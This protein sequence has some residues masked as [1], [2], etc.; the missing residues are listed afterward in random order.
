MASEGSGQVK[1]EGRDRDQNAIGTRRAEGLGSESRYDFTMP[2][3]KCEL[4]CHNWELRPLLESVQNGGC[5]GKDVGRSRMTRPE[6]GEVTLMRWRKLEDARN[7]KIQKNVGWEGMNEGKP[8]NSN[9][10]KDEH[11][12]QVG[13]VGDP[14]ISRATDYLFI[15]EETQDGRRQKEGGVQNESWT[16]RSASTSEE[17]ARNGGGGEHSPHRLL[18]KE[19]G[20][21]RGGW[22]LLQRLPKKSREDEG[23]DAKGWRMGS[24]THNPDTE[25]T[26]KNAP[27]EPQNNPQDECRAKLPDNSKW[28]RASSQQASAF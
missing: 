6:W 26:P 27:E 15:E 4:S 10:P 5:G 25:M 28:P 23:D 22:C 12:R 11:E 21:A 7:P 9:Q 17:G 18:K 19:Q 2:D 1:R 8:R 3:S 16:A 14:P 20:K 13:S 24:V